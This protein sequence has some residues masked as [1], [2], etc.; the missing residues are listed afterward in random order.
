VIERKYHYETIEGKKKR[1][2]E[3]TPK[4]LNDKEKDELLNDILTV[5][6]CPN[7]TQE[8]YEKDK[9]KYPQPLVNMCKMI[10]EEKEPT[11]HRIYEVKDG[12]A[13]LLPQEEANKIYDDLSGLNLGQTHIIYKPNNLLKKLFLSLLIIALSILLGYGLAYLL[14]ILIAR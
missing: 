1:V 8:E 6:P 3:N 11:Q 2:Y 5:E 7:Y 4:I 13:T 10:T 14:G 9:E 12:E